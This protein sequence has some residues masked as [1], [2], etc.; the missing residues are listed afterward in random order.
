MPYV[1]RNDANLYYEKSGQGP[2]LVLL[3]A[4]PFDHTLYLYQIAHFSSC[5]TVLALDFRGF[6]RSTSP[7]APYGLGDLCDDVLA[8]C[9]A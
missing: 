1:K 8:I 5:F 9:Q 7:D 2:A 3:H 4:L 6:G